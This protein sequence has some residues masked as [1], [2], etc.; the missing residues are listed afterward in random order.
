MLSLL[1][2]LTIIFNNETASEKKNI[3]S[4]FMSTTAAKIYVRVSRAYSEWMAERVDGVVA[5]RDKRIKVLSWV[6]DI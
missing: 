1:N 4:K 6:A 3:V 2:T 5:S